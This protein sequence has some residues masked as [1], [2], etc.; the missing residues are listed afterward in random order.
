MRRTAVIVGSGSLVHSICYSL[1]SVLSGP[2]RVVIC[3]RARRKCDEIHY[4]ASARAALLGAAVTFETYFFDAETGAAEELVAEL[5]PDILLNCASHYSPWEG[6][7][8]PSGWTDLLARSGF[9][10]TLPLQAAFA[11]KLATAAAASP[12]STLFI[13]G[14]YP[15]AVNPV[16]KALNVP[17]F[18]GIGNA[19]LVAASLQGAL[20]LVERGRLQV[21]A[22]HL[23]LNVLKPGAPEA[24]AWVDGAAVQGVGDLLAKQ[25]TTDGLE[26]NRLIGFSA[27]VLLRDILSGEPAETCVP[28]PYGLPGG[29]PVIVHGANLR[30]NLPACIAEAEAVQ[31]NESCAVFD[32]VKVLPEGC[33]EF[34]SRVRSELAQFL[35]EIADGFHVCRI[36]EVV[37]AML[38]LQAR[39]RRIPA[40]SGKA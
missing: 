4:V 19:G 18:C 35:P 32:G 17:V 28:G 11:L 33:V 39:L 10:I 8:R 29:Y 37:Q 13:N 34:S 5:Q 1:A 2:F 9:G 23:Q 36:S 26:V 20:G 15:D 40:A 6:R 21:L 14:C 3:A 38:E 24:L 31:W 25:R 30:L 16:L 7:S 22:H 27:A 12:K